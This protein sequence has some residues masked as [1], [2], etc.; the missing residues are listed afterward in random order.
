[1]VNLIQSAV[2]QRPF[3][4]PILGTTKLSRLQEN[5]GA[6]NVRLSATE[7]AEINHILNQLEIDESYF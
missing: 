3:I 1:M 5:L 6:M 7:V 4:V 2:A